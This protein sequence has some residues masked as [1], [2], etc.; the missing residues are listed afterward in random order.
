MSLQLSRLPKGYKSPLGGPTKGYKSPLGGPTCG[1]YHA[2]AL[3]TR[4]TL[5]F[6]A[7]HQK[8]LMYKLLLQKRCES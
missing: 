4:G 8:I 5:V 3:T 6:F 7:S 1:Q 2:L